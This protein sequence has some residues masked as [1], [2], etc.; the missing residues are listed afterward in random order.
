MLDLLC[1]LKGQLTEY[2]QL[3]QTKRFIKKEMGGYQ[4]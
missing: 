3:L 1:G 4:Y 2:Y